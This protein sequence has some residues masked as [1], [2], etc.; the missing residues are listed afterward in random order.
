MSASETARAATHHAA[1]VAPRAR[2]AAEPAE[3]A[4][5]MVNPARQHRRTPVDTR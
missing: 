2:V 3:P 5:R 4:P 1:A